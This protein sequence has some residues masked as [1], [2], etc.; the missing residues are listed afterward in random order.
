MTSTS[1]NSIDAL[2][3]LC[4]KHLA[5]IVA[6][7]TYEYTSCYLWHDRPLYDEFGDKIKD[8]S[9]NTIYLYE[10][11]AAPQYDLFHE[12]GHLF[13]RRHNLIGYPENGYQGRWE[14]NNTQLIARVCQQNH[15]SSYLNLF[16]VQ[17]Q[18]FAT[19]AASELWAEL[20]MLHWL[21]SDYPEAQLLD[22]EML[23]FERDMLYLAIKAMASEMNS[24][25]MPAPHKRAPRR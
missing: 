25:S 16:S 3:S 7:T 6:V 4:D 22:A 13:A 5:G 23:S 1:N 24:E 10:K 20:F 12:L 15:W 9:G 11:S 21:H 14:N 8:L 19:K 2:L 18:D 17:Q